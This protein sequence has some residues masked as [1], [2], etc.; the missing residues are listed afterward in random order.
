MIGTVPQRKGKTM[1]QKE[2]SPGCF[3]AVDGVDGAGKT[4]QVSLLAD[5][6]RRRG[7]DVLLTSEP[8]GGAVGLEIRR[9]L[10]EGTAGDADVM[11]WLFAADRAMHLAELVLPALA[12]GKIVLMDRYYYASIVYQGAFIDD[13]AGRRVAALNERFRRPDL[14]I[15]LLVRP[16]IAQARLVSRGGHL[17]TFDQDAARILK[18]GE[19][20]ESLPRYLPHQRIVPI[21]AGGAP[22]TVQAN[23]IA[24]V[25]A[26]LP[27]LRKGPAA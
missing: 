1:T 17:D 22:E 16:S 4:T 5:E 11:A 6:M 19:C 25:D 20:Y 18:V 10:A 14:G 8:T 12:A 9:R 15:I 26:E 23:I 24:A 7:H 3:I 21:D 27:G 2:L 13:R